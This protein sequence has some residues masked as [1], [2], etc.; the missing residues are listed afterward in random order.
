MP[1]SGSRVGGSELAANAFETRRAVSG[2]GGLG[3]GCPLRR[4]HHPEDALRNAT[5]F[6]GA[7]S[8]ETRRGYHPLNY[9]YWGCLMTL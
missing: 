4:G 2:G 9:R 5:S 6:G 1:H 7:V 3:W 8:S